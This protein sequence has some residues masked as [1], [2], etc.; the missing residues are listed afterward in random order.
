MNVKGAID[1][2]ALVGGVACVAYGCSQIYSPA[3]WIAVGAIVL[4][5]VFFVWSRS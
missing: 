3:A 1:I 5:T 4:G 2:L